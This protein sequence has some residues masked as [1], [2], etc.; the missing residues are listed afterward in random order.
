MPLQVLEDLARAQGCTTGHSPQ[1]KPIAQLGGLIA[2]RSIGQFSTL[3]GGIEHNV[4]GVEAVFVNGTVTRIKN[5]PRRAV[6]SDIRHIIIGNEGALCYITE[7]TVKLSIVDI[8]L[9]RADAFHLRCIEIGGVA[10]NVQHRIDGTRSAEDLASGPIGLAVSEPWVGFREVVPVETRIG[11]S[12]AVAD[13]HLY[14]RAAIRAARLQK[15]HGIAAVRA[16]SVSQYA[17]GR[18]GSDDNVI[19]SRRMGSH[20]RPILRCV[21]ISSQKLDVANIACSEREHRT[22]D[23]RA[24]IVAAGTAASC[25]VNACMFAPHAKARNTPEH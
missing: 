3:Y 2:T 5:V 24:R 13:R 22:G 10:A 23:L 9:P 11:E 21:P 15:Q 7:V 12:L 1:S 18:T 14:P 8:H 20:W 25:G 6:G 4:V 19:D 16:Q 17:A